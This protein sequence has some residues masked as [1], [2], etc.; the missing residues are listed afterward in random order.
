MGAWSVALPF[1]KRVLPLRRL[2]TLM[3]IDGERSRSREREAQIV[4]LGGFL[5][6]LRPSR[7]SNCLE[8]SLLSYRYLSGAGA[9]P[10]IVIA[11]NAA[12]VRMG[13]AWATLDGTP[14][15]DDA[16]L[17]GDFLALA[18]F[19]AQGALLRS[20]GDE[21]TLDHLHTWSKAR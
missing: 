8:R 11:V 19:G 17:L 7:R 6:R 3:W 18:E 2:V 9:A 15:Y 5:T 4:R 14:V 21:R 16:K 12:D 1:L 13:H 20:E 10:T